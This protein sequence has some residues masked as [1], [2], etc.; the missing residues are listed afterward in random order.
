VGG[1]TVRPAAEPQ[2]AQT[3]SGPAFADLGRRGR[4]RP[5]G[6]EPLPRLRTPRL[7]GT[8]PSILTRDD[9][10]RLA[11]AIRPPYAL[12]VDLL[13]YG[14]RRIGQ[15]FALRRR[16][17]DELHRRLVVE[18]SL[19]ETGCWLSSGSTKS[20]ARAIASPGLLVE[21]LQA[22]LRKHVARRP[23]RSCSP[24][25]PAARCTTTPSAGGRGTRPPDGRP[26]G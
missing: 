19:S 17:L 25:A 6:G 22:R 11:A 13:A 12:L 21:A 15:A 5:A 20:Q 9:V 10:A 18:E 1:R 4:G 2:P 8:E 26:A 23:T 14:G 16:C 24:A 3:G 7:P